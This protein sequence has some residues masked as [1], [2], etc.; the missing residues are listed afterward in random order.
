MN[1]GKSADCIKMVKA[2]Q[3]MSID[4][5]EA[6]KVYQQKAVDRVSKMVEVLV[7]K[8]TAQHMAADIRST[9]FGKLRGKEGNADTGKDAEVVVITYRPQ[10]ASEYATRTQHTMPSIRRDGPGGGHYKMSIQAVL[11]SRVPADDDMCGKTI[12]PGDCFVVTDGCKEANSS[13]L[14]AAFADGDNKAL[15]KQCKKLM[16][17]FDEE[18]VTK[19]RG[20]APRSGMT[21]EQVESFWYI[22]QGTLKAKKC[23]RLNFEG[24]TTAGMI[25]G[26]CALPDY[27][28]DPAIWKMSIG[29]KKRLYGAARLVPSG[30]PPSSADNNESA[31]EEPKQKKPRTD[32]T[33]EPVS[34]F[35][36]TTKLAEDILHQC[37]NITDPKAIQCVI[38]LTPGDG[39]FGSL[40]LAR[41]IPY[42]AIALTEFHR[43]SLLHRLE[44]SVFHAY[45]NID[46]PLHQPA[47]SRIFNSHED[48]NAPVAATAKTAGAAAASVPQGQII[49]PSHATN[50][51]TKNPK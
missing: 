36:M 49:I 20:A 42:L 25:I 50:D 37:G 23:N 44:Q 48:D 26:P 2:I 24:K 46:S 6:V 16:V 29:E 33:V 40:C 32:A 35:G 18:S 51:T 17:Y 4:D 7:A 8:N 28:S 13:A 15:A 45:L 11:M 12:N 3:K 27:E 43:T 31:T 38:D 30:A 39:T 10:Q 9:N 19:Q 14:F 21:L 5:E 1:G 47:L 22:S 41:G 34:F